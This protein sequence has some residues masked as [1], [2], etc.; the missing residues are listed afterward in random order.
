LCP[1]SKRTDDSSASVNETIGGSDA[2]AESPAGPRNARPAT[3]ARSNVRDASSV[4]P[5][6]QLRDNR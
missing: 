1:Q 3:G 5:A 2:R 6:V 4:T